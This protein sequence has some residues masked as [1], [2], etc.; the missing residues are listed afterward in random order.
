MSYYSIE[1]YSDIVRHHLTEPCA[2]HT[3]TYKT[4][5]AAEDAALAML[6][7]IRGLHGPSAGFAILDHMERVVQIGPSQLDDT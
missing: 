3:R 2:P 7:E 4:C 1:F 5:E 6:P